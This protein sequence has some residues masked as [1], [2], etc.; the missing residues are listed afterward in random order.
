V[1]T[2]KW[3]LE[4]NYLYGAGFEML[5]SGVTMLVISFITGEFHRAAFTG[6]LW[7]SLLYLIFFGSILGY[8]AYVYTLNNL[9]PSLASVYAYINPIVAVLLG[10]LILNEQLSWITALSCLVTLLGVYMVNTA[11]NK[12]KAQCY[13]LS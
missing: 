4:V 3:A 6:E 10:W 9:P 1:L 2:A 5:F 12:N 7:G 13:E 8:S 11:V